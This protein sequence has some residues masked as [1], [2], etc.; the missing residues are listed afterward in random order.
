VTGFHILFPDGVY[1]TTGDATHLKPVAAPTGLELQALVQ[2]ISERI[3]RHLER[4]G[5]LVRE[6]QSSQLN[7]E[8]ED[9]EDALGQLHGSSITYRIALGPQRGRKA[10]ML[11]TVAPRTEERD[12]AERVAQCNGFSLHAGVAARAE[13]RQKLE[14]V[15]RYVSRGAVALERLSITAQGNIRYALKSAY[16]DGT[17]HV[18]FEP[19]DFLARLAALV[20]RPRVHLT[21]YHGVF[22]PNHRLRGRIVPA[23]RGR[24]S[25]AGLNLRSRHV[26]MTWAQRLKRV[27]DIDIESCERGGED[28]S[29]HRG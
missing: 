12:R 21:R 8:E 1:V 17:T 4:C 10:L 23:Q 6:A 26:A 27:F 20:P 2:R 28:H 19:L 25:P 7:L 3:G 16:R 14:R 15:C 11:Q 5:I 18:V 29:V 13:Q 22:A 24:G 9:S